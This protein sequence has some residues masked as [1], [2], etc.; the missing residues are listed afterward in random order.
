[1]STMTD[2][3][4]DNPLDLK[5]I[6]FKVWDHRLFVIV[7]LFSTLVIAYLFIK[8]SS[9]KYEVNAV[10]LIKTETSSSYTNPND[11][12]NVY[13]ILNPNINLQNELN[14]LQSSP[15]IKE[16]LNDLG[17]SV[18]Y[19]TKV[20]EIPKQFSF[21]LINIYNECPFLVIYNEDHVQPT[22]VLFNVKILNDKEFFLSGEKKEISLYRLDNEEFYGKINNFSISG[23]YRFGE[24][25]ENDQL[26]FKLLLN[27]SYIQERSRRKDLF[28]QFNNI[29]QLTPG[30]QKSLTIESS[31][32]EATTAEINFKG[33]NI[34]KSLDFVNGLILKYIEKNLE[35]K[36]YLALNTI[37]YID[38]QLSS[39]TDTL[40][41][42]EQQLQNFQRSYN[43]MDVNEKS[44]RLYLQL[45]QF[46]RDRD[47]TNRRLNL[48][49]QMKAYFDA[50]K[51]ASNIIIPSSMGIDDPLL[52]NMI[53]ELMTFNS[54]KEQIIQSNQ[55][56]NPRLQI[57][58]TSIENLEKSI[59]DNIDFSINTT[60][61]ELQIVNN[62][63]A[64]ANSEFSQLPQTQRRLLGIERQFN[65]TQDVYT[66]LMEKRIQA[67]IA[68]AS[69]L[70]D[71]EIIEPARYTGTS[72]HKTI[73]FSMAFFLGLFIPVSFLMIKKYFTGTVE[74]AE[75]IMKFKLI[76]KIGELPEQKINSENVI[77]DEPTLLLAESFRSIQSN[78]DFYLLG[79]KHKIILITSS[80]PL[81]G[82]SFCALN[83]A[84]SFAKANNKTLLLR[85]D[86]RKKE[87]EIRGFGHQKLVGISDFLIAHVT[88]DDII[89]PTDI[90]NLD[91]IS[92]GENPPNPVELLTSDRI[93]DLMQQVKQQYD[94]VFI[95][96][97]PF[98]LV[99]DA[100]IIMKY[101]DLN[102]YVARIGK[103]TSKVLN[104]NLEVIT[105][106]ELP[107]V[108]LLING[109]KLSSSG[110]S[111]YADYTYGKKK[112]KENK[113]IIK[114]SRRQK[115]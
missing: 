111:K 96:T 15:L 38:N 20:D 65:I 99:T 5:R 57:L 66:S 25:I 84:T 19:F 36:N 47:N 82:K 93:K 24:P 3:N 98:G 50:N 40:I 59:S 11:L 92:A 76:K 45:E 70:P 107:N 61:R 104:K 85:F 13:D 110:Y 94:Y 33:D 79:K 49:Q 112:K 108:F 26:S 6:L 75:D 89:I 35:K 97:P 22:E 64:K 34:Q 68:R 55:L 102:L 115:T 37:Q 53:Q 32:L 105:S 43:I 16:V 27:S 100:F 4:T 30:Y 46:E 18:S 83:L 28:F 29:S 80:L 44:Q 69:T 106:K 9:K 60:T 103:I 87:E 42:T 58:N 62:R 109:I 73:I 39:I 2:Q 63:I 86:L 21:S 48:L 52:N 67:Q 41:Q 88:L 12:L 56:R 72:S 23:K 31:M 14:V 51:N 10:I 113:R 78:I 101:T 54:E 71:C 77:I 91:W 7:S 17:L 74:D 1:M 95:D 90:P 81:E 114:S 8:F